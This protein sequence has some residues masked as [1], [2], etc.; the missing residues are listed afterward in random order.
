MMRFPV[1]VL[2]A[3]AG[4]WWGA[5]TARAFQA[6]LGGPV[7]GCPAGSQ[8]EDADK[9]RHGVVRLEGGPVAGVAE[10]CG[11]L[12]RLDFDGRNFTRGEPIAVQVGDMSNVVI[13]RL[14]VDRWAVLLERA[15]LILGMTG[16]GGAL[17]RPPVLEPPPRLPSQSANDGDECMR[18]NVTATCEDEGHGS[19]SVEVVCPSLDLNDDRM[20]EA[21]RSSEYQL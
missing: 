2:S 10:L 6:A 4:R 21:N 15:V 5:S 13:A 9:Q 16:R 8:L 11:Q 14:M 17:A 1:T 12:G 7:P 3:H 18:G 20:A 19:S